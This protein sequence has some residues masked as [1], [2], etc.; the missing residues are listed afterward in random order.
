MLN[1]VVFTQVCAT[2]GDDRTREVVRRTLEDGTAWTTGSV[3][4]DRA[5]LRIS[6]SNWSTTDADVQRTLAALRTAV[7]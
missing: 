1:D 6:V 5:I 3:W 2:F 4:R 7:S